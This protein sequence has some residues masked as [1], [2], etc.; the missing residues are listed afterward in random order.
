MNII[1]G[2]IFLGVGIFITIKSETMLSMF[3]RIE[4]FELH[5]GVEGGSRLG[6]KLIG[7]LLSFFGILMITGLMGGFLRWL[8]GPLLRV[9]GA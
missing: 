5:L 4:F 3:G 6:Y 7:I 8:L 1:G 9:M 2:L